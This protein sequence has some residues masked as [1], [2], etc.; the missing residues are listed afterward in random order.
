MG[1]LGRRRRRRGRLVIRSCPMNNR[2]RK[3]TKYPMIRKAPES[4]EMYAQKRDFLDFYL[5][6]FVDSKLPL[7]A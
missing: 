4:P 7:F 1:R 3:L 2:A 6:L 5:L